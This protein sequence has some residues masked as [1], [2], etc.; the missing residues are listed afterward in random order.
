VNFTIQLHLV[1]SLRITEKTHCRHGVEKDQV[2][3]FLF[4]TCLLHLSFNIIIV[5]KSVPSLPTPAYIV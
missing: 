1:S 4:Y 2:T 5:N 3:F